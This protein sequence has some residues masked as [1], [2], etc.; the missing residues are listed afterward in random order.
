M[1]DLPTDEE[2]ETH[3]SSES[4]ED[5][6]SSS[7][8]SSSLEEK[9]FS[10]IVKIPDAAFVQAICRKRGLVRAQDDYIA[11][12]VKHTS[13]TKNRKGS[14]DEDAEGDPDDYEK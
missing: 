1:V 6:T 10:S 11:L 5:Q 2:D 12:D 7:D 9:E 13:T 14:S 4:K 3:Q 8:S